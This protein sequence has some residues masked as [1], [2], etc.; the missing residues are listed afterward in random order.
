MPTG[1]RCRGLRSRPAYEAC[2]AASLA[3]SLSRGVHIRDL[4]SLQAGQALQDARRKLL[5]ITSRDD[6]RQAAAG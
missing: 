5:C 1:R 4:E 2:N 3:G 6:R